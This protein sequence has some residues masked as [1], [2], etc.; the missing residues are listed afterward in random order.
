VP[1]IERLASI[2][3]RLPSE[4][5][6][7]LTETRYLSARILPGSRVQ[8]SSYRRVLIS[9]RRTGGATIGL[10]GNRGV[11]KSEL[12]RA[13]CDNPYERASLDNAGTIGVVVAAPVAYVPADFLRL[14]IKRIAEQVPGYRLG[15]ARRSWQLTNVDLVALGGLVTCL[16]VAL[17]LLD[18]VSRHRHGVGWLL[19]ALA[20]LIVL[21]W[22]KLRFVDTYRLARQ[23]RPSFRQPTDLTA[24][25]ARL[26]RLAR[27]QLAERAEEVAQRMRY[28]E[29][30]TSSLETS[31]AVGKL[32]ARST[33]GFSLAQ[34]AHTEA[35]LVGE[36]QT[37]VTALHAGGY[38]VIVGIDE[39]DKQVAGD[40]AT[41]FLNGI[42]VLFDVRNCSFILT[43]SDNAFAQF[44]QRGMPIRDV[45]DSSLDE[46][47]WVEHPSF[48]EARRL[49]R[50]RRT[51]DHGDDISDTQLLLCHTMAG[52]LPRDL[53]RYARQLS[54]LSSRADRSQHLEPL[55]TQLLFEDLQSRIS[56]V[57]AAVLGR[58]DDVR[59]TAFISE[60]EK[61]ERTGVTAATAATCA[62]FL[63]RDEAFARLC[64]G[65]DLEATH[66]WIERT[67]R[68]LYTYLY[69]ADT[70]R[71]SF[72]ASTTF[73]SDADEVIA[74]FESL[75]EARRRLEIDAAAGWRAIR[76]YRQRYG[77]PAA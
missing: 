72:L 17:S 70:V 8:T 10:A 49:V 47:I 54:E 34:F 60:M 23:S 22:F 46:V 39:L 50:A 65:E 12:L 27:L 7:R 63:L 18:T 16:A 3:F 62:E 36:F 75:A 28:L 77:L 58:I 61:L 9:L 48:L 41:E 55:V 6:V 31:A 64:N 69:F 43:V 66:D 51:S 13:F 35:D 67:R 37:F 76:T 42:K 19:L 57:T 45:F 4:D 59:S 44:A 5:E 38:N 20:L 71:E 21:G 68:Q 1:A 11:G 74:R 2:A 32:G 52:G 15:V 26:T 30:R 14:L 24:A 56:G 33:D 40:K 53:L 29:T 73:S 25:G